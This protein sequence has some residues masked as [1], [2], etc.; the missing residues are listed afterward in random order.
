MAQNREE[1]WFEFVSL[2][3]LCTVVCVCVCV[4]VCARM[5]ALH[6]FMHVRATQWD[7][8]SS[9]SGASCSDGC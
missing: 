9:L 5:C 1:C 7:R 8:G 3:N 6:V 2:A 4:C